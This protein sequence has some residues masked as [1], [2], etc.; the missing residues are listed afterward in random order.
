[1]HASNCL[2]VG[3]ETYMFINEVASKC[4]ST[5]FGV[6]PLSDESFNVI[7]SYFLDRC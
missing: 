3:Q 1:M 7:L 5:S 6:G 4:K 2:F